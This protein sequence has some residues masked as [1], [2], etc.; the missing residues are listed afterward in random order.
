MGKRRTYV[1]D[2]KGRFAKTGVSVRV[3]GKTKR[4]K[5][6]SKSTVGKKSGA[7]VD[8]RKDPKTGRRYRVMTAKGSR[9]SA[10]TTSRL[11]PK[12]KGHTKVSG[13]RVRK[14]PKGWGTTAQNTRGPGWEK[15]WPKS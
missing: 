3:G 9:Y 12:A 8:W 1:R 2:R 11:K 10:T 7:R 13:S 4:S 15:P 5:P 6:Y 14:L